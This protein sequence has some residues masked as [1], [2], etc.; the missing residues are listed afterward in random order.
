MV[1]DSSALIA[2]LFS[3]PE[4]ELFYQAI[5]SD[6]R[7]IASVAAV[8]ETTIAAVRKKGDNMVDRVDALTA[9]LGLEIAPMDVRQLQAARRAFLRYGK[10]RHAAGLNFG[11]CI[12]YALARTT[13]EA[14]LCKGEDFGKTDI[15]LAAAG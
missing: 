15:T 11:D 14:L 9:S 3:E 6:S 2:I 12:S 1:I 4:D 8:L 7:R 13:G 5:L 10:G